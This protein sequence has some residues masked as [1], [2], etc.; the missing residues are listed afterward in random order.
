MHLV[1]K[2]LERR[3][4]G[5]VLD[6]MS[7]CEVRVQARRFLLV[8]SDGEVTQDLDAQQATGLSE[9]RRSRVG[10]GTSKDAAL[11]LERQMVNERGEH[12]RLTCTRWTKDNISI[13]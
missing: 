11:V 3:E 2:T 5:T 6:P 8:P 9:I 13:H 7:D 1:S 12:S 4:M 10:R